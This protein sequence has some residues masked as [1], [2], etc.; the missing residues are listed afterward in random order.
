MKSDMKRTL[1]LTA[2]IVALAILV[3]LALVLTFQLLTERA[4]ATPGH[5]T[6]IWQGGTS[7][8]SLADAV[9]RAEPEARERAP[10]AALFRAEGAWRPGEQWQEVEIPPLAWTLYYYSASEKSLYS[11][12]VSDAQNFWAPP[13]DLPLAPN[14]IT[15]FPPPYGIDVAWISF[16]AADG[17]DFLRTHTDPLVAVQLQPAGSALHWTVSAIAGGD[18]LR[19]VI[20]AKTGAMLS[21][22]ATD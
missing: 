18:Q 13:T 6:T 1:T 11:V 2:G 8:L 5:T 14:L 3:L 21:S 22:T 7:N 16:R 17:D 9:A 15:S 20:N 12:T 19:V 10:D 4:P